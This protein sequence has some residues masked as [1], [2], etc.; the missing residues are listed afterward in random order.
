MRFLFLAAAFAL[1]AA[2]ASAQRATTDGLFLQVS[3]DAQSLFFNE[4]DF[5]QRDDG[6]G[7][8]LRAG[9]GVSRVV[10]L[11]LGLA[12]SRVEGATNGV[13]DQ[14]YDWGGGEIGARVNLLPSRRLQPYLDVA[15]RGV[16]ARNDDFNLEFRGGGVT[17][18]G[19]V[20]Y[21]VSPAVALDAGLRFGG[22]GFNEVQLGR[23]SVDTDP[24]DLGYGEGRL[25]L[26]ATFYPLR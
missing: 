22:G 8:S 25:S 15:L 7:L 21:F 14:P 4:D 5:D 17:V 16:E 9:Y 3:A 24:D 26:G 13:I 2:P 18:G 12:G 23:F 19:G 6:T 11:Y 10:T 1:I 20:A